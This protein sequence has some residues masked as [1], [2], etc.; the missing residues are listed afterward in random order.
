M[1]TDDKKRS[2]EQV[3]LELAKWVAILS[4]TIDHYGRIVDPQ[5]Q[6][7][8][9]L[10]GRVAF[11][12]FAWIV[13]TRLV[14]SP[15]LARRYLLALLPWALVSQP[16]YVLAGHQWTQGNILATLALG[17]AATLALRAAWAGR[18][19][20]GPLGLLPVLLLGPFVEYGLLGIALVPAVAFLA[21]GRMIWGAW[22]VGPL[23]V[24]ANLGPAHGVLDLADAAAL[25][26][27]AVA[28]ASQHA[29]WTL[30]RLPKHVFYGYYP[31]H[32]YLLHL[33]NLHLG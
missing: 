9:Q 16:M 4:M 21:G 2:F 1:Q 13:G 5:L 17:V 23:G 30:P 29:G 28:L 22:A 7:E 14:L 12:L 6:L 15:D 33:A 3:D 27:T 31:V 20:A 32:L 10:V 11:P 24:L 26:A 25:F 8:T 18:W 19:L